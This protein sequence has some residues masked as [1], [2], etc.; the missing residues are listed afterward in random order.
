VVSS[1]VGLAPLADGTLVVTASGLVA[2]AEYE[3]RARTGES[4]GVGFWVRVV[5]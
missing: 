5:R 1:S 3:I 2:G 4:P